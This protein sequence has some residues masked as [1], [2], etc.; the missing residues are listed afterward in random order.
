MLAVSQN[1]LRGT[2]PECIVGLPLE[3]L[4]LEDNR[5]HGPISE[6]SSLGQYLKNV[7]SLN[8]AQ[9]RW[10]PLLRAEKAALEAAVEPLGVTAAE[11][12]WAGY[13][14]DFKWSYQWSW[15]PVSEVLWTKG[16]FR[17]KW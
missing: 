10:A 9:N 6:Y 1:A 16:E 17:Y 13:A 3:W 11:P 8:L 7:G 4:W 12:N 5:V 2:M 14:W 15:V